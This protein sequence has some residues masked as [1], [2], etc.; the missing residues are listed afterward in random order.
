MPKEDNQHPQSKLNRVLGVAKKL[1]TSGLKML[2]QIDEQHHRHTQTTAKGSYEQN[3]KSALLSFGTEDPQHFIRT[4]FPNV[5]RQLFGKHYE[6]VTQVATF[7]SPLSMDEISEYCFEKLHIFSEKLSAVDAILEQTGAKSLTELTTDVSRSS[8]I[9]QALIEQN[10]WIAGV[11]GGFTGAIGLLGMGVDIPASMVLALRTIYQT[12]RA[13]GFEL[14]EQDQEIVKLIFQQID[15]EQMFEKQSVLLGLRQLNQLLA[16]NDLM[17]VQ[18]ILGS[19]NDDEWLKELLFDDNHEFKWQ[20]MSHLPQ[21]S[22]LH[23]VTPVIAMSVGAM[24]SWHFIAD[25]GQKSQHVFS[26]ARNYVLQHPEQQLSVLAAYQAGIEQ[27]QSAQIAPVELDTTQQEAS[28]D[29][30]ELPEKKQTTRRPRRTKPLTET[31]DAAKTP[32]V[33]EQKAPVTRSNRRK[34]AVKPS[35]P[36]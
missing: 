4:A 34:T 6:R 19:D 14:T 33:V 2:N 8:R 26:T 36:S 24:Y 28:Q 30:V 31:A 9:S 22:S 20:W 3:S 13:H 21:V 29:A 11:Q 18:H 17:A 5:S 25:I 12:G 27:Q 10:K 35:N 32:E 16:Q 7:L 1:S 15:F 23:H